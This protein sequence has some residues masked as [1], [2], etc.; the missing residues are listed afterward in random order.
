M[1]DSGVKQADTVAILCYT[2]LRLTEFLT[3]SPDVY[4]ADE[5]YIRCGIKTAAGK[6]ASYLYTHAY[7]RFCLH[8]LSEKATR[9]II[10]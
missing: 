6:T 8:I 10:C 2:G 1:A 3:L 7:S 5:Q 4:N 9:A